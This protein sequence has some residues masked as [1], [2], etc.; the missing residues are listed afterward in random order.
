MTKQLQTNSVGVVIPFAF[1]FITVP[2]CWIWIQHRGKKE[3]HVQAQMP[4]PLPPEK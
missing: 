4:H 2:Q 3:Q 1:L